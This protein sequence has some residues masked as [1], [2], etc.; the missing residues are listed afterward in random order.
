MQL[1]SRFITVLV[2]RNYKG[3]MINMQ[4]I[5]E[6]PTAHGLKLNPKKSQVILIYRCRADISHPMLLIGDNGVK[7]VHRVRNLGF[8]FLDFA[9]FKASR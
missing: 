2:F 3:V 1:T 7:V 9:F 8:V 4:Q 5:H 6:R